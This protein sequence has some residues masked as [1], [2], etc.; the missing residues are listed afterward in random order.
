MLDFVHPMLLSAT[1]SINV[2]G[3]LVRTPRLLRI[4]DTTNDTWLIEQL[5]PLASRFACAGV[6]HPISP[7]APFQ[8]F[9]DGNL[10]AREEEAKRRKRWRAPRQQK[11]GACTNC[12]ESQTR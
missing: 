4:P 7:K 6:S 12:K 10:N 8:V 11:N 5:R 9:N 3:G 2:P 1:C